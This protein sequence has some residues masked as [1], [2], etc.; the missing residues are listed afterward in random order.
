MSVYFE[1]YVNNAKMG[2][3]AITRQM[4]TPPL[5]ESGQAEYLCEWEADKDTV[6]VQATVMHNPNNGLLALIAIASATIQETI[7]NGAHTGRAPR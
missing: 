6:T 3:F 1:P 4:T 5:N 7:A 2:V